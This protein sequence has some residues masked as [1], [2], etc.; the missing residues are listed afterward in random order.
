MRIWVSIRQ[1]QEPSPL[2]KGAEHGPTY[3]GAPS[4]PPAFFWP[5]SKH[6]LLFSS[7][8]AAAKDVHS[9]QLLWP[10]IVASLTRQPAADA[11]RSPLTCSTPPAAPGP[12]D[13][14]SC[15]CTLLSGVFLPTRN[16]AMLSRREQRG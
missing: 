10:P 2:V 14:I 15:L 4:S 12:G 1:Q 9:L 5:R 13:T 16:T 3:S 7:H 11:A 8:E 6:R